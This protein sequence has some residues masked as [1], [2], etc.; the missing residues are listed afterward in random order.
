MRL[1]PVRISTHTHIHTIVQRTVTLLSSRFT[2][3]TAAAIVASTPGD[4]C[5]ARYDQ[6]RLDPVRATIDTVAL[7]PHGLNRNGQRADG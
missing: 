2:I 5:D 6:L 7:V 3:M 1:S 4:A